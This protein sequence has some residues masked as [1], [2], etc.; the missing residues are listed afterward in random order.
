[1]NIYLHNIIIYSCLNIWEKGPLT[2]R[3]N[4]PTIPSSQSDKLAPIGGTIK[5]NFK[6]KWPE[7]VAKYSSNLVEKYN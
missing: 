1:M 6:K 3:K 4:L 5:K 7:L 2:T